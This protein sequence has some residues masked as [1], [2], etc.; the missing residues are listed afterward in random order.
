VEKLNVEFKARLENLDAVREKLRTLE[1]RDAGTDRQRDTYFEVPEGRLKLRE[2]DIENALIFYRRADTAAT[3]DSHVQL[4]SISNASELRPVLEAALPVRAVVEKHREIYFVGETKI[5][6]DRIEN[7]GCFLEV[8]A[9]NASEAEFF[10]R[11]FEL[12]PHALEGRSY[13]DFAG[14]KWG[15][16]P[17][18]I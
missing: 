9:P 6:L 12:E 7:H 5:H 17:I 13:A 2:G 14:I 3:R 16:T 11:F 10:F 8:E 18:S 15:Q 1:P 4:A